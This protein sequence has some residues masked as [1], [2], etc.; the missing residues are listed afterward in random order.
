MA[1]S[2]EQDRV[3]DAIRS[4]YPG[5]VPLHTS[6]IQS[7]WGGYGKIVRV[8]LSDCEVESVVVKQ[9][10]PPKRTAGIDI[11]HDRKVKSYEVEQRFYEQYAPQLDPDVA[12]V[13]R[14]LASSNAVPGETLMVLE[15]MDASGFAGGRGSTRAMI[16]WLAGFH[17]TFLMANPD[18]R[19]EGTDDGGLWSCGG[20]HHLATRPEELTNLAKDDPLR[21][22]AGDFDRLLRGATYQ[23][24]L[25]G[26]PKSCNMCFSSKG[27][28]CAA[29]DFQYTGWGPGVVDLTYG[30]GLG[31]SPSDPLIDEYFRALDAGPELEAEWRALLPVAEADFERFIN[32]WGGGGRDWRRRSNQFEE[33]VK[34][35]R[36]AAAK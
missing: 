23:T 10:K 2:A 8:K 32:G 15:D 25:H 28:S 26:D 12:R 17:K 14:L 1:S 27:D 21:I 30:F 9:V 4:A 34:L 18:G 6:T 19:P 29:V 16:R 31:L 7:L 13:P 5:A 33:A 20:T 24:L 22:H 35:A 11:G 3:C 36:R